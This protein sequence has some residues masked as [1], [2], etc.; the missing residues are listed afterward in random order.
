M[1]DQDISTRDALALLTSHDDGPMTLGRRRFLQMVGMGVG[2]GALAGTM[3]G[4]DDAWAGAPIGAHEGILVLVGFFGGSDGLNTVVPYTN[5]NYY[6]Q[7]GSL[8]I[9][10][11]QV[12]K[13]NS[14]VGL[15][16]QL[17]YLKSL[18]DRG[19]VAVVQGVGYSN[20]DLSHFTSMATWM[21]GRKGNG[22]PTTGWIGRWLDGL[23]TDNLLRAV[24]VGQ[25]LPLHLLGA[26]RRGTAVPQWG[27]GFGDGTDRHDLWMYDAL[28]SMAAP[29]ARGAWQDSVGKTVKSVI[30]V[31]QDVAPVFER[32]LPDDDL[33]KKMTV[34]ARLI[35][36]NLGLR[37]VDLG[38][39]GFDTHSGQPADLAALMSR[40]DNGLR[41]FF[42]TLDDRFRSRV[43]IM[44]YSE[45]GRTSWSND[46]A[47]TDHGTANNHFVIGAGVKGGL[48]GQQPSLTGLR[49]WDRMGFHVDFRS[50]YAS[51][52]DGW[53]GGGSSTVLGGA[54]P[55]LGLFD[56]APGAGVAT[57]TV[58]A[59]AKGDFVALQPARIYDSR[60]V[61]RALPL[62]AGT[63]AEVRVTGVGGVPSTGVTG[64][65]LNVTAASATEA[66]TLTVWPT[67]AAKPAGPNVSAGAGHG[68]ANMVTVK[69][70][71][72]GRV[73]VANDLGAAHLVV[74]VVGYFR[75]TAAPRLQPRSPARVLDTRKGTGGR[76]GALGPGG[77]YSVRIRGVASVPATAHSVV[78]NVTAIAPSAKGGLVLWPSGAARPSTS[79]L[80]FAAASTTSNLVMCKIGADGKVA[81]HNPFGT[82]HVAMDVVGWFDTAAKGRFVPIAPTRV[83]DTRPDAVAPLA[84]GGTR[85]VKVR[86]TGPV[87]STGVSAVLVNVTAVAPS[88]ATNITVY[89]SGTTR[90]AVPNIVARSGADTTG[91]VLVKPG[92][93][94]TVVVHNSSGTAD[95]IVDVVGWFTA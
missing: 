22:T 79:S 35:N 58:P 73:N 25:G 28:R 94:G 76:L 81:V 53:M 14:S 3:A 27:L 2:A 20:P 83:L 11:G 13:L 7:H 84:V 30:D 9:P 72:L 85:A 41:T 4:F 29:A 36:A 77:S 57:G 12:L 21:Y 26:A 55:N 82:T 86:G 47:G 56:A 45:F 70:G 93:T 40:F 37:V 5:G 38:L 19:D 69:P 52:L 90:P 64:V 15:H 74:D 42:T 10:A 59:A 51:V 65:V 23:S 87:P 61:P 80:S 34:A 1:L 32:A 62:G 91:M 48:Y 88:A 75:S 16:P 66:T 31:G 71:A 60:K 39:D 8:A 54:F 68:T 24:T 92:A 17:G 43:T 46:S 33:A 49:R 89:P 44:T 63:M 6:S 50:L 18:W 67:G 95:V 78:V